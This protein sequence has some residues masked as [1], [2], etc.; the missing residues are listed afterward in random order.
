[1]SVASQ[2]TSSEDIDRMSSVRQVETT[3]GANRN[4]GPSVPRGRGVCHP[5]REAPGHECAGSPNRRERGGSCAAGLPFHHG[6]QLA[7]DSVLRSALISCGA[8]RTNAA[9]VNGAVL[10]QARQGKEAKFAELIEATDAD[11]S[12]WHW[13]Q[14]VGGARR[15]SDSWRTRLPP[16]RETH[17]HLFAWTKRWTRMLAVSCARS[18]ATSLVTGLHGALAGVDGS[19]PDLADLFGQG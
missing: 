9:T 19:A 17:F 11:W 3:G 5:Q 4:F 2:T 16:G 13:R 6:A 15:L 12:W 8:P 7:V 1:M 18:F 14:E 10:T